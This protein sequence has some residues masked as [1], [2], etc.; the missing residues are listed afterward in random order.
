[1]VV[2][3]SVLL[4]FATPGASAIEPQPL[5]VQAERAGIDFGSAA[6]STYLDDAPFRDVLDGY[7]NTITF[8][9]EAKW[10]VIH[11]E[12]DT[13]YFSG[14]DALAR[15]AWKRG[16]RMR[17]H[18][19]AWHVQNPQ[20]LKQL[21]PTRVEAMAILRDHIFTVVNHFER[22]FPGLITQWDVVNEPIDND[23]TRRNSVWQRWIGPAYIDHAF[24]WARQAAGPDVELHINDYFDTGL[25]AGAE[26]I[27]GDFD[28]GDSVPATTPGATGSQP[29]E[30]VI[31]CAAFREL[32]ERLVARGVPI[33]GVG[34]QAHMADANP[35][36]Y[37]AL[38]R[39]VGPLGLRW[40]ITEADVPVPDDPSGAARARQAEGFTNALRSCLDDPACSTYITWGASDRYT[41]WTGLT[42]GALDD[43]LPYDAALEPKPA[44][45]AIGTALKEADRGTACNAGERRRMRLPGWARRGSTRRVRVVAVGTGAGHRVGRSAQRAGRVGIRV[46][47]SR[48]GAVAV[49]VT[50]AVPRHGERKYELR[51]AALELKGC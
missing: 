18:V 34:F 11:P 3:T 22:K 15:W 48:A 28:D 2:V 7:A 17:G 13:Y 46:G 12:P 33:D 51:R 35:S 47:D 25:M 8:E 4:G 30:A 19:L 39:W 45:A 23:G 16:V 29:C 36:N 27:G 31:K 50:G 1:M 38:T 41:W 44:V 42:A 40:A 9:N 26:A 24:R 32:V 14:A 5:R 6:Q 37:R 20:W 43:A 10:G 49:R 21:Q